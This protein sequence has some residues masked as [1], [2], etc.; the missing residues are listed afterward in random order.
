[1]DYDHAGSLKKILILVAVLLIVAAIFYVFIPYVKSLQQ[2]SL[3]QEIS[4]DLSSNDKIPVPI[5]IGDTQISVDLASTE[6][7][8]ER[9][10]GGSFYLDDNKG[11]LFVFDSLGNPQI[12]MKD[13]IYPL[14]I[15]WLGSDFTIVH[16]EKNVSPSTYPETFGSDVPSKYVLEVNAGFFDQHNVQVGSKI[17]LVDNTSSK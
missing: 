6:A 2:N 3:D 8:R 10:L 16:E 14:D 5:S 15:A 12:W 1:M 4:I 9:G 13:M 11:M 17:T 7:E